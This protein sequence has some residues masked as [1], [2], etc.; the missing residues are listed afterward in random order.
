M[1]IRFLNASISASRSAPPSP[2]APLRS[3][4]HLRSSSVTSTSSRWASC[5]PSARHTIGRHALLARCP[6]GAHGLPS[7]ESSASASSGRSAAAASSSPVSLFFATERISSEGQRSASTASEVMA[8]RATYSSV[9]SGKPAS[10]SD[11]SDL[12][13]HPSARSTSS[14]TSALTPFRLPTALSLTSRS[15]S[16]LSAESPSRLSSRFS[17]TLSSSSATSGAKPSSRVSWLR[18]RS[19]VTSVASRP[20]TL[21]LERR[22][23]PRRSVLS[24]RSDSKP[25]RLSKAL[26]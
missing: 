17:D 12:I 10:G 23:P 15:V 19:S 2:P 14:L 1:F 8:L 16:D 20:A 4:S 26:S 11:A 6:L 3:A 9:S 24:P 18:E 21:A 25:A 22:F 5:A 7:S 13:P